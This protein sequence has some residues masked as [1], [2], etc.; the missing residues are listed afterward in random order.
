MFSS[1]DGQGGGLYISQWNGTLS[2]SPFAAGF[3]FYLSSRTGTIQPAGANMDGI[4]N[5]QIIESLK[6]FGEVQK[7]G[8][9]ICQVHYRLDHF[10][11]FETGHEDISG[12]ITVSGG[13][14][15]SKIQMKQMAFGQE[16]TLHLEDE[17]TLKVSI[18]D[19]YPPGRVFHV[20]NASPNGFK[21]VL[22]QSGKFVKGNGGK[23]SRL[24]AADTQ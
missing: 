7:D 12:D 9:H 20:I 21:L 22:D 11:N 18:S 16:I 17:R 15:L 5:L 24:S 23:S 19:T 4:V 3:P 14:P 2:G 10:E 1:I 6:G 8:R 13:K